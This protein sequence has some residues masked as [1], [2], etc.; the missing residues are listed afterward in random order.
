MTFCENRPCEICSMDSMQI[1]KHMDI[2]TAKPS[3]EDR[4]RVRHHLIDLVEPSE[5]YNVNR[6]RLDAL[7]VVEE[8]LSAGNRPLFVGG[9]G[10]YMDVLKY[11]LFE[12]VPKDK[13]LR[14]ELK[15]KEAESPGILRRKLKA[16]D[17][18]SWEKIHPN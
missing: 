12:G 18:T 8:V 2:G 9:T 11:G 14:E 15:Q 4:K 6:Y 17:Q 13:V 3:L 10:L 1:Y 16:I 7:E 5:E